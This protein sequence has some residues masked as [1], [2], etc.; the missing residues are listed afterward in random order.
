VHPRHGQRTCTR[1]PSSSQRLHSI[2]VALSVF[3]A[4][5]FSL[6]S[7][8]AQTTI[9]V[10]T[11]QPT[12]QAAINA[13]Q[14]GDTVLV[15]PGTY[16]E[17]IDF[18][19]K[20]ITVTTSA[21]PATT[22]IDGGSK[23]PVV[24][25]QS[26]ESRLSVISNFT[27]QNGATLP[28]SLATGGV[29]VT[30]SAPTILGNNITSNSCN[31]IYVYFGAALIQANTVSLTGHSGSCT[32]QGAG[33]ALGGSNV[34]IAGFT[35]SS[36]IGNTVQYNTQGQFVGG[37]GIDNG[38][39][40]VIQNNIVRN[41]S[42][43][44]AGGIY[45]I[46][47]VAISVLQNLVYGNSASG[48]GL[49]G[50]GGISIF[51]P[52][53]TVG[54]FIGV[55]AGNTVSGNSFICLNAGEC[56]TEMDLE[57]NL[58]QYVVVNNVITGL[59]P[60]IPATNCGG[61]YNYLALTPLVFDHNDIYNQQGAAYGGFCPD[62][63]GT[64]GNIS[65]DPAFSNPSGG[66]YQLRSGSPA[67]DAGN[68][69]APLMPTTDLAGSPR[70]QDATG[71]GYP[72]VDMG[73]Y[74]F[75]GL[76]DAA[77]TVL[78]LTPSTF[79]PMTLTQL[80]F[81]ITLASAA[82]TPT[83]PVTILQDNVSIGSVLV[84]SSGTAT[85]QGSTATPGLHAFVATYAGSGIFSP[86]VSVKFYLLIPKY[87]TT[88]TFTSSPNPSVLGQPVTFTVTVSSPD[89][90]I[91]S[92][93]TVIDNN[94]PLATLLPNSS[95]IASITTAALAL[96]SHLV[97]ASYAGDTTHQPASTSV[98]QNVI[99][100]TTTTEAL[101][102]SLNPANY[103]QSVTL[104]AVVTSASPTSAPTG[105][106]TFTDGSTV[107]A[108]ATLTNASGSTATAAFSISTLAVGAHTITATY[109]PGTGFASS[110][111]TLT[112][113]ITG[114]ATTEALTSS[115]NP[116]PYGQSVTFTATITST[117]TAP[118]G[119]ITFSDGTNVVLTQPLVSTSAT[120][121][122][123]SFTT[124]TLTVGTHNIIAVYSPTGGFSPITS[125]LAEV[126]NG[127]SSTTT[128]TAAPN[129][130]FAGQPVA[131]TASITGAG[132]TPTGTVTFYDGP[133]QLGSTLATA[134]HATFTTSTLAVGNHTLTAVYAG[135]AIFS[136]S[137]SPSFTETIKA[138]PQ[139]FSITLASPT[140]TIQTQHHLTT[141]LTL[142]SLNNFSDFLAIACANLP[143]YVTC[144][145][146][147]T[148]STLAANA[149]NTV[150]LYLDTDSVLGY[151]HLTPAAPRST[152]T[153]PINLA[154][155]LSPFGLL[156]A[157]ASRRAAKSRL[158]LF[159]LLLAA[160]L[161]TSAIGCGEVIYPYDV[162]PFA[163]T[164]TY[165]IPITATGATTGIAHTVNLTLQITP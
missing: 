11:D 54:P 46:N 63:T 82:G 142:T 155:I 81:T 16:Y 31:G 98:N 38:E 132:T 14:T 157:V 23:G 62:Q 103:G 151:A 105:A 150:S 161:I 78:T 117:T 121:S 33:I 113:N 158:R 137:T 39:G 55:I 116:A 9:H 123:A 45:V 72:I 15:A 126:I 100:G 90:A 106:V 102:S 21:G 44:D 53:A 104:T 59:S 96:G 13:A 154:L 80:S 77:P 57:G 68:N 66:L 43:Q 119:S 165:T 156:A 97:T 163:A 114:F 109:N 70:I 22:I 10:P 147:P 56:A 91:L 47:T 12:I 60:S 4:L 159:M 120:A 25:F 136:T 145:P 64:Y 93:I 115:L 112:Q 134:G 125:N 41:N 149:T 76:Q 61:A 17:N 139:D 87:T 140:L 130:Q 30:N 5:F 7:A 1:K 28:T 162:P 153:S 50:A 88:L 138:L 32:F 19:G 58:G 69:S 73:A 3:L 129:P 131:L 111:A 118:T 27:L 124:S 79:S 85:F 29:F 94:A 160:T 84:G 67:I 51:P 144:K 86:A 152:P 108:I 2:L 146:T 40:S 48:I 148:P 42:G 34:N 24:T 101:S 65:A 128:L 8:N 122:T 133:L 37:I 135:S 18:K 143:A 95:G 89:H 74:E 20:A 36:V 99:A 92:P 35:H 83:G 71:K 75:A 107:L 49:A 164:G 6:P 26:L 110:Q 127:L 141:T 52:E